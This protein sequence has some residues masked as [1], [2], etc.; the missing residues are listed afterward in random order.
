MPAFNRRL[1]ESACIVERHRADLIGR[2]T[3]VMPLADRLRS[4]GMLHVE[5]YEEIRAAKTSQEKMRELFKALDSGG[6]RVKS[7]FYCT[8]RD[9]HPYLLQDLEGQANRSRRKHL[10]SPP[11]A[12]EGMRGKHTVTEVPRGPTL[13]Q[14]LASFCFLLPFLHLIGQ[15]SQGWMERYWRAWDE[16]NTHHTNVAN[17]IY[18]ELRGPHDRVYTAQIPHDSHESFQTEKG[19]DY[20]NGLF[21]G[22]PKKTIKQLQVMQNAAARVF[23]LRG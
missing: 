10:P 8:L 1:P 22:L 19:V 16:D 17:A 3:Q 20:C 6:D 13:M 15:F 14:I 21:T 12:P 9:I 4:L 18:V 23:G 7:A 11:L 5:A 2:I